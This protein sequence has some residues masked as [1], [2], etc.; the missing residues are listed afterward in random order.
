MNDVPTHVPAPVPCEPNRHDSIAQAPP[1]PQ[2]SP[3]GAGTTTQLAYPRLRI[4]PALVILGLQWLLLFAAM[5]LDELP[6]MVRGFTKFLAPMAGALLFALWWLFASRA[7][8]ADRLVIF[9]ALILGG[10]AMALLA[11]EPPGVGRFAL[12]AHGLLMITLCW[13]LWLLITFKASWALRRIVLLLLVLLVWTYTGLL[14]VEGFSGGFDPLF[15]WR[16]TPRPEQ[17]IPAA[18]ERLATSTEAVVLQ[19]GDWPGFRGADRDGRLTGLR[20]ATDLDKNPPK[21]VWRRDVG[22]GWS[23]FAVVGTRLYTQEQRGE[24]ETVVCY[25]VDS[26]KELWAHPDKAKFVETMGGPG[27]RATPTFQDGKIYALG[28]TGILN[29]LDAGTGKLYWT[30]DVKEA[31]GGEVPI[32]GFASSPL[33]IQGLVIVFAGGPGGKNTVG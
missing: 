7:R 16:W 29:C 4:W 25:A 13:G 33:A 28:A 9:A 30:H 26:G 3:S 12:L 11:D 21:E 5:Y 2:T 8:W 31:S 18:E 32:W 15:V 10:V 6:V 22:A 23:S 19:A 17:R 24:D 1:G 20:I 14:R 27:P